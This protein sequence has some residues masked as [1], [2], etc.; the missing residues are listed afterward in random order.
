MNTLSVFFP[1][2]ERFFIQSVRNYRDQITDPELKQAIS[3]FIGQEAFHTREHEEYNE[4][5][6]EAGMPIA[7]MESFVEAL[8]ERVQKTSPHSWQLAVTVSLE[9]LTA[10]LANLVLDDDRF[11]KNS[12]P[13][14]TALWQWH[15]MEE[16]EHK[17][18]A[19]DAY[20]QAVGKGP[21]AYILRSATFLGA[22]VIFWSLFYRYYYQNVRARGAHRDWR[23]WMKSM[24]YQ[25]GRRGVFPSLAG[26]WL[27]FFKPGFHPWDKDNR[28]HLANAPALIAQTEQFAT[29]Q[30]AAA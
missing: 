19:F 25:F 29:A 13:H 14:Y 30:A 10:L 15:A 27:S 7:Q 17:G 4:A 8:L 12:D 2:G 5:M 6:L 11:I 28:H 16:T 21:A 26:E 1:A 9:H 22:N 3:A 18:V 24:R 20:E 23:G